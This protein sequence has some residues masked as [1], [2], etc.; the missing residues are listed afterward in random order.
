MRIT[1]PFIVIVVAYSDIRVCVCVCVVHQTPCIKWVTVF[2][3]TPHSTSLEELLLTTNKWAHVKTS[4]AIAINY[5]QWWFKET[6]IFS[7]SSRYRLCIPDLHGARAK[8]GGSVFQ[9]VMRSTNPFPS[10]KRRTAPKAS[11][12]SAPQVQHIHTH[13]RARIHTPERVSDKELTPVFQ[14]EVHSTA[15]PV[16]IMCFRSKA[17]N[18]E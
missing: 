11:K 13:T 17:F 10:V 2:E 7:E 9:R 18:A 14:T 3:L 5:C 1:W 12:C 16:P 15:L 4:F 6:T 8:R